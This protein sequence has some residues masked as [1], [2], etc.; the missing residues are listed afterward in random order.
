METKIRTRIFFTADLAKSDRL[1]VKIVR[2]RGEVSRNSQR[3]HRR[4][5]NRRLTAFG[6]LQ[7][8]LHEKKGLTHD[9]QLVCVEGLSR[10]E[11]VGD[12]EFILERDETVTFGCAGSLS[13]NHQARDDERLAVGLFK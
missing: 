10:D 5:I 6:D 4:D 12:A 3:P 8:S 11:K 13:A 1:L 7:A 9:D 2:D